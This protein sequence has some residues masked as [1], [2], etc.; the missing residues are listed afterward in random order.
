MTVAVP[1]DNRRHF[2]GPEDATTTAVDVSVALA[3]NTRSVEPDEATPFVD[4]Y[5]AQIIAGPTGEM[6]QIL[7]KEY[8]VGAP[9]TT[10]YVFRIE[11]GVD[12]VLAGWV[13]PSA[14]TE[15]PGAAMPFGL[16][17][18]SF[19]RPEPTRPAPFQTE[20]AKRLWNIRQRIVSSGV[21]LLDWDGVEKEVEERRGERS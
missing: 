5:V 8:S 21:P 1:K 2:L 4:P 14:A 18:F 17:T 12:R 6:V 13:E 20:L 3:A 16:P 7:G 15:V 19:R 11:G 9:P 10:E